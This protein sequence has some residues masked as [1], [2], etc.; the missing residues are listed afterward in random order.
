MLYKVVILKIFSSLKISFVMVRFGGGEPFLFGLVLF[1]G[2]L[3][4]VFCLFV[5]LLGWVFGRVAFI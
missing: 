3:F 1:V 5:C 4:G 2:V